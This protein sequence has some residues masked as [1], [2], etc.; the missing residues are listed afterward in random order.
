VTD[1]NRIARRRRNTQWARERRFAALLEQW[2]TATRC[3]KKMGAGTCDG[4]LITRVIAHGQTVIVC[5]WCERQDA[6]LC[7]DCDAPVDGTR[8]KALRCAA[9]RELAKQQ[10]VAAYTARH[11]EL[12]LERARK[13][14]H[15]PDRRA[16]RNE[17][18]RAWRKANPEKVRAQKKRYVESHRDDEASAYKK[19]HARYRKT[20]RLH[21][22]ELQN[23]RTAIAAAARTIPN[24]NA[25]GK[26]T[27]WT[28]VPGTKSGRPGAKC[29]RCVFPG[30][31]KERR[32]IRRAAAK[33]IAA[34]P[35]FSLKPKPV[36]VRRPA[37]PAARGLGWERLC[38]TPGCEIVV[39][40][41]KKKC[42]KCRQE[43]AELARQKL[44]AGHGRG[45]RTDLERVA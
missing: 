23:T 10:Q 17:Y 28:P 21:Y 44:A 3:P 14:Y 33:R 11:H 8:R 22:R 25:C 37:T 19:Y 9:H 36:K 30:E 16:H 45:R 43:A 34:D 2:K 42:T 5:T 7:R 41:R 31:R 18:K 35:R 39:T 27:Q 32:R 40:H 24:C 29:N 12:V 4:P 26:P 6:G 20:H 1:A 15:Q 13:S 38:I